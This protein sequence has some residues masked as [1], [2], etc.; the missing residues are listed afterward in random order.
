MRGSACLLRAANKR[1]RACAASFACSSGRWSGSHV[2]MASI[3]RSDARDV[4]KAI[5]NGATFN[6]VAGTRYRHRHRVTVLV[7]WLPFRQQE[8]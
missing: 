1:L 8:Q 4:N 7:A 5:P 2:Q 6:M 3:A